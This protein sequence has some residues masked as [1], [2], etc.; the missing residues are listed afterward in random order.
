MFEDF[1]PLF[2]SLIYT[3]FF[4]KFQRVL[5]KGVLTQTQNI[6]LAFLLHWPQLCFLCQSIIMMKERVSFIRLSK[7]DI[8][9][10]FLSFVF[11]SS[12]R[13]ANILFY[14]PH[15][16]YCF[17]FLLSKYYALTRWLHS[18]FAQN[19]F[20]LELSN[21]QDIHYKKEINVTRWIFIRR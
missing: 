9:T 18:C 15:H 21:T 19:L 2:A 11:M 17:R 4:Y 3:V 14:L 16:F 1:P 6:C 12:W 10:L 13:T 20:I 5:H 7:K 8:E